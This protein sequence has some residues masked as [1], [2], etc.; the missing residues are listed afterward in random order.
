MTLFLLIAAVLLALSVS[1]T[2]SLL[3]AALLSLTP[4]QVGELRRRHPAAGAI[5]QGF[6]ADV[7][8]PISVI[9]ICNTAAHTIGATVA[10]A[11]FEILMQERYDTGGWPVLVFG[12]VFT[13]LML[14]FTEILPKTLGVRYNQLVARVSARP[15]AFLV[16]AMRP[17]L[18]ATRLANRPFEHRREQDDSTNLEE[19]TTLAALARHGKLISEQQERMI[20][21]A[22]KFGQ[23][24]VR[25]IMTPRT[26][27]Q[28]LRLG[29][30][31]A[32]IIHALH[33]A[34]YTRLPVVEGDLDRVRGVLHLRDVFNVLSLVPGRL[35]VSAGAESSQGVVAVPREVARGQLQVIG[36]GEIDLQRIIRPVPFVPDTQ[37][38]DRLLKLFQSGETHM[39]MVVDEYGGVEGLVTLE[40]VLEEIVGDIQDE[41]DEEHVLKLEARGDG[42]WVC[43][44]EVPLRELIEHLDLDPHRLEGAE[45]VTMGGWVTRELSRWPRVGDTLPLDDGWSIRVDA[46][47]NGR[48]DRMTLSRTAT[49]SRAS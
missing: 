20:R 14:Q 5:W 18:A 13:I 23:I 6:K 25:Q 2:C 47:D 29:D 49:D 7:E 24:R 21:I 45:V 26:D 32:E 38:L 4:G 11:E 12:I 48:I 46:L 36:W 3:E 17:L 31:L 43:G 39:A 35:D 33:Q 37:P 27:V 34:P 9:L 40:D 44:G 16:W 22:G 8:K 30:G 15:M 10:G 28:Y 19:I 1:A 42:S 41:F